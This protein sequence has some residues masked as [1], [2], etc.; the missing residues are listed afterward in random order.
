VRPRISLAIRP[1]QRRCTY[2]LPLFGPVGKSCFA[3]R[4][5]LL[6]R[7][8]RRFTP[9][10]VKHTGIAV[11]KRE[12]RN[13]L[14]P[15]AVTT[16]Q[17]QQQKPP[18]DVVRVPCGDS[19][20]RTKSEKRRRG[21]EPEVMEYALVHT[22]SCSIRLAP[23]ENVLC[24]TAQGYQNKYNAAGCVLWPLQALQVVQRQQVKYRG[25]YRYF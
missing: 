4:R 8:C 13:S 1:V 7:C 15:F 18:R 17:T 5:G 16:S 14:H 21:G 11:L 22:A 2:R 6:R 3:S 19:Q 10:I 12:L 24:G 20:Q 25:F 23:S 9:S